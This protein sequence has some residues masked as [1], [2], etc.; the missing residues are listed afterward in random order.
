MQPHKVHP[1]S[2]RT[3]PPQGSRAGRI[4]LIGGLSLLG[5]VGAC[6]GCVA[7]A[8]VSNMDIGGDPA[9]AADRAVVVTIEDVAPA[10]ES[11]TPDARFERF[12]HNRTLLGTDE[13]D[14]EYD[15]VG[16]EPAVYLSSTSAIDRT[17]QDARSAYTGGHI[18]FDAVIAAMGEVERRPSDHLF[19]WGDESRC[20][21][22]YREGSPVGTVFM[23]RSDRLTFML[24]LVGVYYDDAEALE[25][26]LRPKLDALEARA[27][28]V[29]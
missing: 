18:G 10:F 12:E 22:L 25:S 1:W 3:A 15:G 4:L 7:L 9:T 2:P 19:R 14:Y 28:R 21:T 23:G 27:S 29:R 13:V 8:Y 17:A 16:V 5:A 6:G 26:I 24:V 20:E 11:F